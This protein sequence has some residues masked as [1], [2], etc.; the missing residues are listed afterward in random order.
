LDY[1]ARSLGAL[2]RAILEGLAGR[3]PFYLSGGAALSAYFLHHRATL[4]LDLFVSNVEDLELLDRQVG[5]MGSEH[6]WTV[7]EL[8]SYPGFRRYL[9]SDGNEQTVVDLVHEPVPQIVPFDSKPTF[10]RLTVDSLDDLVA[11]KLG[12][13][14]GRGD[15]KDLVDLYFL[16]RAG[17][18]VLAYFEAAR[19]KDAGMEAITLAY[20]LGGIDP[21]PKALLLFEPLASDELRTFRDGLAQRLLSQ[22]WPLSGGDEIG[23]TPRP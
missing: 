12:A 1:S 17:I 10:A 19:R 21:D 20:V 9:V 23:D 6:G 16:T 18:D 22:A 7:E 8:Q 3:G 5:L 4:D 2:Q 13:V 15:V 14:L 11:N